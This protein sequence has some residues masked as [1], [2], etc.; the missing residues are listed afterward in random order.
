MVKYIFIYFY[1]R[2]GVG[3]ISLDSKRSR[4]KLLRPPPW[5]QVVALVDLRFLKMGQL[6]VHTRPLTSK[7]KGIA[8]LITRPTLK[9]LFMVDKKENTPED[10]SPPKPHQM[11]DWIAKIYSSSHQKVTSP[12]TLA[13]HIFS[14]RYKSQVG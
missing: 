1:R 3:L 9:V 2:F 6:V 5:P 12:L 8:V 4:V 10:T 13:Q 7:E 14:V 11:N